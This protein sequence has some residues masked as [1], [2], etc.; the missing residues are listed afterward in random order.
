MA[1]I[2]SFIFGKL[3]VLN[4]IDFYGK[5]MAKHVLLALGLFLCCFS[6][7][8]QDIHFT[9][10]RALPSTLNP[11]LTGSFYGTFR[12]SGIYRNQWFAGLN[13][14][15]GS[16]YQ[17]PGITLEANI[18]K[19]L[20]K[21]DW[22]SI[23]TQI[24][25]DIQGYE[26]PDF[27]GPFE[28]QRNIRTTLF[29][30]GAAYHLAL[31]EKQRNVITLGLQFG[32]INQEVLASTYLFEQGTD[33][34]QEPLNSSGSGGN[35]QGG[36]ETDINAGLALRGLTASNTRY[37]VGLGFFHIGN[38]NLGFLSNELRD[39]SMINPTP[40]RDDEN[41]IGLRI[42]GHALYEV[43]LTEKMSIAPQ[44]LFQTVNGFNEIVLQ[45]VL[46]Y[47]L[48]EDVKLYGGLGYRI[49]DAA[50]V[51]L[52]MDINRI[53]VGV[54]YDLALSDLSPASSLEL[55]VSYIGFVYKKPNVTPV[56]FCPR[57]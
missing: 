30:S 39:T 29:Y 34:L 37:E 23:G 45:G 12:A 48:K 44:A 8:A 42:A 26:T 19:G 4:E 52:G 20:R 15:N 6:L 47:D 27:Q 54:G 28:N 21:Q 50:Q 25:V 9:Q 56:I 31:D 16:L 22:I 46:G 36:G 53:K 7:S 35:N 49:G 11:A 33:P 40:R 14:A 55:T 43:P 51:L 13:N 1:Y 38:P 5:L 2:I 3:A 18:L 17:T 32:N 24:V 57:F 10:F 41:N